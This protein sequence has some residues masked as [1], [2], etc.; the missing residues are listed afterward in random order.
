MVGVGRS[1]AKTGLPQLQASKPGK[2]HSQWNC[3]FRITLCDHVELEHQASALGMDEPCRRG[4]RWKREVVGLLPTLSLSLQ[5]PLSFSPGEQ[6]PR[7]M[8]KVT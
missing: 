1:S 2:M 3:R 8:G 7:G 4:E 6:G 5:R